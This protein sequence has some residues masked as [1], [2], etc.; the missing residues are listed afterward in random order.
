M[1]IR[2]V[3]FMVSSIIGYLKREVTDTTVNDDRGT[4]ISGI[5]ESKQSMAT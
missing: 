5:D 2:V 3:K 1:T 4:S